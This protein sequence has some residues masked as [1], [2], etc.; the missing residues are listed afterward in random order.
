MKFKTTFSLVCLTWTILLF[1]GLLN[2]HADPSC[3]SAHSTYLAKVD[4]RNSKREAYHRV[5]VAV[6]KVTPYVSVP[7]EWKHLENKYNSDPDGFYKTVEGLGVGMPGWVAGFQR[8]WCLGIRQSSVGVGGCR[9][10]PAAWAPHSFS[11]RVRER[12]GAW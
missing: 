6:I 2:V 11:T 4:A 7:P 9:C 5:Q 12:G 3:V 10:L 8:G 1:V